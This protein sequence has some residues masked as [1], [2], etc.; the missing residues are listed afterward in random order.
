[1]KKIFLFIIVAIC[2]GS[3][4]NPKIIHAKSSGCSATLY[5]K[6]FDCITEDD[7]NIHGYCYNTTSSGLYQEAYCNLTANG[8]DE[9]FELIANQYKIDDPKFTKELIEFLAFS[10]NQQSIGDYLEAE[11]GDR[12]ATDALPAIIKSAFYDRQEFGAET[13][14]YNDIKTAY[15]NEKI[16]HQK[17]ETLKQQF[18]AREMWAD[19]SLS[20]TFAND[21]DLIVDLNLIEIVLFGSKAKWM[22]DVSSWPAESDG[23]GNADNN[24]AVAPVDPISNPNEEGTQTAEGSS[25]PNDTDMGEG[26]DDYTCI[27]NE[28]FDDLFGEGASSAV[29]SDSSPGI[30]PANCGDK[31]IDAGES[32]DDGNTTAGD[33]CSESCQLEDGNSLMCQDPEA[34]S[35]KSL[36]SRGGRGNAVGSGNTNDS[37]ENEGETPIGCP[38]GSTGASASQVAAARVSNPLQPPSYFG[39]A[40]L[41]LKNY[42]TVNN[43]DCPEGSES[44]EVKFGSKTATACI[45][46]NWLC[47]DFEDARRS[48]FGDDYNEGPPSEILEEAQKIFEEIDIPAGAD[49]EIITQILEAENKGDTSQEAVEAMVEYTDE[50]IDDMLRARAFAEALEISICVEVKKINRPESPYPVTEGCVHC[51]VLGMIDVMSG[52]LEKSV[53]PKENNMAAWGMSNRWGPT[54]SFNLNVVTAILKKAVFDTEHSKL[55]DKQETDLKGRQILQDALNKIDPNKD[56]PRAD[57]NTIL[58]SPGILMSDIERSEAE[59]KAFADSLE[60]YRE[61]TDATGDQEVYGSTKLL[62]TKMLNSFKELQG[63]YEDLAIGLKFT[64]KEECKF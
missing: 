16:I 20:A 13:K 56:H 31:K 50:E 6:E 37:E 47:A 63:Q 24:Q 54:F 61:V 5:D 41:G 23:E 44:L 60:N 45:D 15:E 64:D 48:L 26:V 36:S 57:V 7:E 52:M 8:D 40:G 2:I 25:S 53:S 21:F 12:N 22:D 35:F 32:C 59:K 18:K 27:P 17:K 34:V 43:S 28:E 9:I 62:L 4:W 49:A 19:G 33:G 58:S 51:H 1:M 11:E 42:P 14:I 46:T 10:A 30:T 55:T 38:E 39:G 29:G 3:I